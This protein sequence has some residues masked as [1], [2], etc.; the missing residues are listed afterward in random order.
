MYEE[1]LVHCGLELKHNKCLALAVT[2][3]GVRKVLRLNDSNRFTTKV[4]IGKGNLKE[5]LGVSFD[6]AGR[7]RDI[8]RLTFTNRINRAPIKLQKIYILMR[9]F[10]TL[11]I[12]LQAVLTWLRRGTLI[13][14]NGNGSTQKTA[15]FSH[16]IHA[17]SRYMSQL[18][19]EVLESQD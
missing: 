8:I 3:F 19:M 18:N 15:A 2:P 4:I 10:Y 14:W 11:I 9:G 13:G 7:F 12:V 5:Y 17:A 16:M 1:G 6:D